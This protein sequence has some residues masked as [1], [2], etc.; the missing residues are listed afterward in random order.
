MTSH[1]ARTARRKAK[2]TAKLTPHEQEREEL[3][4]RLK[5]GNRREREIV[6]LLRQYKHARQVADDDMYAWIRA[7]AKEMG[8]TLVVDDPKTGTEG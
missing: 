8:W 6:R 5:K 1:M 3:R 4:R 2:L 7:A